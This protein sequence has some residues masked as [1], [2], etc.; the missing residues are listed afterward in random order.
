MYK[1]RV[2][3]AG[4]SN[5]GDLLEVDVANV[6]LTWIFMLTLNS[7][8]NITLSRKLITFA[9]QLTK[10]E[11]GAISEIASP[12]STLPSQSPS[13]MCT[14]LLSNWLLFSIPTKTALLQTFISSHQQKPLSI[15]SIFFLT[16]FLLI[17]IFHDFI[18]AQ[19]ECSSSPSAQRWTG[20]NLGNLWICYLLGIREFVGTVW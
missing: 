15:L 20:P 16:P 10:W 3:S 2:T 14:K 1:N 7:S 5:T 11:T 19:V 8:E 18:T 9:N 17:P 6:V 13:A 12:S 4:R